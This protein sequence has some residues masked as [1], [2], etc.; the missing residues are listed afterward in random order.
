M[1]FTIVTIDYY[2]K[3]VEVEPLSKITEARTTSFIWK[4][5]AYRFGTPQS[6]VLDN[7]TQF[8]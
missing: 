1:K 8:N 6:L 4:N 3:W 2:T 7:G 5:I